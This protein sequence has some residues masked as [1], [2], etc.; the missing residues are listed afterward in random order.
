MRMGR[1]AKR[2]RDAKQQ[3][4]TQ[5]AKPKFA[6]PTLVVGQ[7][8]PDVVS[9]ILGPALTDLAV[10]SVEDYAD[11]VLNYEHANQFAAAGKGEEEVVEV[12]MDLDGNIQQQQVEDAPMPPSSQRLFSSQLDIE[13]LTEL[14]TS[15]S[16][17]FST[18]TNSWK[19]HANAAKFERLLD[20]KYGRFRPFIESH[21]NVEIFIKNVQRKY[22]M[23]AFS[24][25]RK[26]GPPVG[27]TTSIMLLF[28]MHRNGVRMD[29]LLLAATFF[30]VGLQPWALV[31]LVIIGKW[32]MDRRKRK[33]IGGM[34]KKIATVEAYYA[35]AL[36]DDDNLSEEE[37]IKAKYA[38]LDTPVGTKF[39][40]AD[41]SLR[42]EEYDVI[43]L[44][45]GPD[46]LYVG[47]LL[48]R[49]GKKLVVLS[50]SD[51]VSGCVTMGDKNSSVL[52]KNIPFDV[53]GMNVTQLSRQQE[54]L[55][56]ALCT[57]TD[58][59]GGIRFSRIGS[60]LDGYA[61]SIL[62]VPGLGTDNTSA[63]CIPVVL[64][65]T[66]SLA[67]LA[68]YCSTCLG[69][70]FP[71][72]DLDGKDN[73]NSNSLSYLKACNQ[74]N[75]GSADYYLS[76]LYSAKE[77]NS[78]QEASIRTA[79][80]FLNKCLPLNTHVRSLMAAIG[81]MNE[82]LC[83][84][85]TS[86]AAHVTNICAM[87]SEE[88]LSYPVGGPRA[89]CHALTSVI[90]QCG[91][92]VV[93]GV[94][95]Q[96][97]LFEKLDEKKETKKAEGEGSDPLK[98]PKPKCKG[99][100][101][102]NGMEIKVSKDGGSVISML[103]F[104]PTF[105]NLLPA[106][107]RTA[108]GVPPGLPAISERRPLM[109]IMLGLKGSKADLNLT[110]A[111]WYRLPNAS[112]PYDEMDQATGQIRFGTIGVDAGGDD[113]TTEGEVTEETE[114]TSMGRRGKQSKTATP[115]I[116]KKI[117]RRCK[118]Q[119][120][121]SW[122]KVSFPSAKDPSWHDRYGSI[123][124]C[125]VTVEAC[126]DFVRAFD[127]KPQIY[128]ILKGAGNSTSGEMARLMDR[129]MKDLVQTF[130]QLEDNIICSQIYGPARSGLTHCPARFAI[131]GN[132]PETSYPGLFV[133]GADLTVGD[134]FS[135]SIVGGWMAANAVMGYS[136]IDHVY[137]KKNLTSDLE[138]FMEEP[139]LTT[140]R[141]GVVVEDVAVPF[142]ELKVDEENS[143]KAAESSKE[144]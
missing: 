57:S 91:G 11:A 99:I 96:E 56:P 92:R 141:D 129:V 18:S 126:D 20:E 76:K 122:M 15:T 67:S 107:T 78:Y 87:T 24:P 55:A 86:M 111:D 32:E 29:A 80:T 26:S 137:L 98:G 2:R 75:A 31:G 50:P 127:T 62:S 13:N 135:A 33:R 139:S 95:L 88:G 5:T 133:G 16:Q 130:P 48:A 132:R 4:Q 19:V 21:P 36:G 125:V 108:H 54:L 143:T 131:K 23:G 66:G 68:E 85:K 120:G 30:L 71:G 40:P 74:I 128:S 118:F 7:I 58:T 44:G 25:F 17:H 65:A 6:S 3:T 123:S 138:Q 49:A 102:Q 100:R 28:M 134:S 12:E 117:T 45:S 90:E 89:I 73:G 37:E 94:S 42:D 79:S 119:T 103:G 22:A 34:S 60:N 109:K 113:Q 70:G 82:N 1:P 93:A 112:L 144:E 83:P 41:L 114:T 81:M 97:L 72:V 59:Q 69:D 104:I 105:L 115:A 136:M 84:D 38:L 63:E 46:T 106:E 8:S 10:Q 110:G 39:N 14:L 61:H 140:E 52:G 64:N 77:S 101:L 43:V 53:H 27:K 51:D 35:S 124:T 9:S 116:G 142:K 47:A 121:E